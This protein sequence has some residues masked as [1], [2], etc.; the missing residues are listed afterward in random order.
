M[1]KPN[2]PNIPLEEYH[3]RINKAKNLLKKYKMDA[4]VVY[5]PENL[6]YYAGFNKVGMGVER[7]WRIGFVIPKDRD[8]VFIAPYVMEKSSC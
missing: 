7:R 5:D 3:Q 1:S 2:F 8:P 4:L 6:R